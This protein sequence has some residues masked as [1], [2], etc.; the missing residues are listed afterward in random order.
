MNMFYKKLLSMENKIKKKLSIL[1][2]KN[3]NMNQR[4]EIKIKLKFHAKLG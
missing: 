4:D 1:R 3:Q 2:N